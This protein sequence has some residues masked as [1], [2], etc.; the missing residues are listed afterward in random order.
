MRDSL[1][2]SVS[3]IGKKSSNASITVTSEPSLDQTLPS[4]RPIIPA[5]T[6]PNL[7]GTLSKAKAPV[8]STICLPKLAA[9]ISIGEEPVAIIIFLVSTFSEEPSALSI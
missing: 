4:S 3:V 2:I 5:P 9:G 6:T 7:L 8:L 1:E